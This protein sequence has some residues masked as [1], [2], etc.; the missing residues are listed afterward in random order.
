MDYNKGM[1]PLLDIVK[2]SREISSFIENSLIES[3]AQG[4]VVGLSGG[5]DSSV[6]AKL[7]TEVVNTHKILGLIMPGQSTN[8]EDINDAVSLADSLGIKY[9]TIY[10]D[11]LIQL[12]LG[13][14][15]S[16]PDDEKYQMASA[17]LEARMR[18][19]ILYFH[20]NAMNRL[21]VGTDNRS[22]LL[23]GYFTKYGDGGVDI[24]PI[25]ALYKTDVRMLAKHIK[26]PEKII[27][28]DPTAGL[29]PG[30]TDEDEIGIKYSLLDEILYLITEKG[31]KK[32]EII[33]KLQI[34]LDEVVKVKLMMMSAEHKLKVPPM[35]LI[36]R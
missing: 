23:V 13:V 30:Q 2:V 17:N 27:N 5:L 34:N 35:P 7:C 4:L 12:V 14:C 6:T 31:M 15:T 18:M 16:F 9:K 29:W 10:I 19:L 25:G 11:P 8:K 20:A 26:I 22:E 32:E 1:L 21:V 3:N 36:V 28:K 33:K 24:L